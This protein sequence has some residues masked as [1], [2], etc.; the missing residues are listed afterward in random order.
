[1]LPCT[2]LALHLTGDWQSDNMATVMKQRKVK[3]KVMHKILNGKKE[4]QG[5]WAIWSHKLYVPSDL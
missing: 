1:V 3:F 5:M 4:T 2:F